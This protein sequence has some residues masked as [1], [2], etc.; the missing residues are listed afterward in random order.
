MT[1]ILSPPS[2]FAKKLEKPRIIQRASV[3]L[4]HFYGLM[5]QVWHLNAAYVM[6]YETLVESSF[7]PKVFFLFQKFKDVFF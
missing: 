3:T 4:L 5:S 2:F 1:E 7:Y 6:E